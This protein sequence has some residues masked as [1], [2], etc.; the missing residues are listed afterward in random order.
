MPP[1]PPTDLQWQGGGY[2]LVHQGE[3]IKLRTMPLGAAR[4]VHS[5]LNRPHPR[6]TMLQIGANDGNIGASNDPV[7]GMLRHTAVRAVLVEAN[8]IIFVDLQQNLRNALGAS[9]L[10]TGR[11]VPRNVAAC[12]HVKEST[13][14]TFYVVDESFQTQF[15]NA[16]HWATKQISSV[17]RANVE[18][19][20]RLALENPKIGGFHHE[21]NARCRVVVSP[22]PK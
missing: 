17:F 22:W 9:A 1:P 15:T 19:G 11:V 10:S 4:V 7:Q 8:P 2:A 18:T 5:L 6:L 16:P 13:N 12:P 20:V 21:Q 14:L 3:W